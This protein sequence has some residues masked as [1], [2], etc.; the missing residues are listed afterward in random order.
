MLL[1]RYRGIALDPSNLDRQRPAT[2]TAWARRSWAFI[3]PS[4]A[5]PA[6][7][8]DRPG[9]WHVQWKLPWTFACTPH[10]LYLSARCH[11]CG[12]RWQSSALDARQST[13]CC[14]SPPPEEELTASGTRRRRRTVDGICGASPTDAPKLV[15][16]KAALV[17]QTQIDAHLAAITDTDRRAAHEELAALRA[18]APMVLYMGGVHLAAD[19]DDAARTAWETHIRD[20]EAAVPRRGPAAAGQYRSYSLPPTNPLVTAVALDAAARLQLHRDPAAWRRFAAAPSGEPVNTTAQWTQLLKFWKPPTGHAYA[21]NAVRDEQKFTVSA[22]LDGRSTHAE[23]PHSGIGTDQVPALL[24]ATLTRDSLP[25]PLKDVTASRRYAAMA[26]ARTL[27]PSLKNWHEAAQA[28]GIHARH[29]SY[30]ERMQSKVRQAGVGSRWHEQLTSVAQAL[31]ETENPTNFGARRRAFRTWD[32]F[33]DEDWQAVCRTS[34]IDP[35]DPRWSQRRH[36]AAAWVWESITGGDWHGAPSLR[37]DELSAHDREMQAQRY[38]VYFTRKQLHRVEIALQ[39]CVNTLLSRECLDVTSDC[40]LANGGAPE[41]TH[42][43]A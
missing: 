27:E 14:A 37:L 10:G 38:V 34:S 39:E 9:V 12:A 15:A 23:P 21:M 40:W 33:E 5:C 25:V 36:L 18:L 42:N 22:A 13:Q 20:R 35:T 41:G 4:L 29:A 17:L 28:V 31:A 2:V 11:E 24:S 7:L 1:S 30:C 8:L 6:C 32:D 43:I 3:F 16:S 19:F 26:L